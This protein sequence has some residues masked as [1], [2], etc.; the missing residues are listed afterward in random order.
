MAGRRASRHTGG[1]STLLP[2]LFAIACGDAGTPAVRIVTPAADAVVC[3]DP[4][5]VV[6]EVEDF[7]LAPVGDDG[8]DGHCD[9]SLNGQEVAMTADTTLEIPDVA[10]GLYQLTAEL[11]NADHS[12][13]TPYAGDTIYATVDA[14]A[15]P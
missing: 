12:A 1:V 9:V 15:C 3:G 2:W 7:V 5:V 4:L 8:G 13:I 10:D 6:L 14:T 11:V